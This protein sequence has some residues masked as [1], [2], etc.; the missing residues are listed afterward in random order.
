VARPHRLPAA[1]LRLPTAFVLAGM[2]LILDVQ[3]KNWAASE[4]RRRGSRTLVEGHLVLR[5]QLNSGIAFGL[6]QKS[7]H[8]WKRPLLLAYSGGAAAVVGG[9]LAWRL[10]RRRPAG[11]LATA[12]LVA[13]LAGTTGNFLDRY[14]RAS[15]VDFIDLTLL[16][17]VQW[18]AFNLADLYLAAGVAQCAAALFR[19]MMRSRQDEA[20]TVDAGGPD[21]R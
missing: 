3:T 13:L 6:F 1:V 7:L 19:P 14:Y 20:A 8:P 17:R 18:P 16:G 21:P 2:L 4:L 11:R 9:I 15:V 5:Y 12:G 10:L